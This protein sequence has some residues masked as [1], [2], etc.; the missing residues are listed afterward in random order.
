MLDDETLDRVDG[1]YRDRQEHLDLFAEQLRRWQALELSSEQPT[2]IEGLMR[3]VEAAQVAVDGV[4][5]LS[6][7]LR[8]GTI[9][10]VMELSDMEI[11][12]MKMLGMT[13]VQFKALKKRR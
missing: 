7:E 1:Q 9:E 8:E 3:D 13:P 10:R 2:S 11:G 12:L 6:A 5:S 4:L